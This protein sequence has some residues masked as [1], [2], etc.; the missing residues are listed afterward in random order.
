MRIPYCFNTPLLH[1][2]QSLFPF[3]PFSF[4]FPFFTFSPFFLF[5]FFLVK[6]CGLEALGISAAWT[7]P[8]QISRTPIFA[9]SLVLFFDF[10]LYS[11]LAFM[12]IEAHHKTNTPAISLPGTNSGNS[13]NSGNSG[14][15][16]N[17]ENGENN[18]GR[19]NGQS[20]N[21]NGDGSNGSNDR[22]NRDN[23]GNNV[24]PN[25]PHGAIAL[26]LW[27]L[28]ILGSALTYFLRVTSNGQGY[29]WGRDVHTY[30]TVQQHEHQQSNIEIYDAITPRWDMQKSKSF[31]ELGS[32]STRSGH[33]SPRKSP[34]KSIP[35]GS[36]S[37]PH[38][39]LPPSASSPSCVVPSSSLSAHSFDLH[40]NADNSDDNDD[41]AVGIEMT[42]KGTRA[43]EARSGDT[44]EGVDDNENRT[45]KNTRSN[46]GI[47]TRIPQDEE[48]KNGDYITENR[49]GILKNSLALDQKGHRVARRN[50]A[51]YRENEENVD[52]GDG[53]NE[54]YENRAE[55][56]HTGPTQTCMRI[57]DLSK[58][59]G[60]ASTGVVILHRVC[61]E[62]RQGTVTCLL[63]KHIVEV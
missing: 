30:A 50:A 17:S 41:I 48:K 34:R 12:A 23:S 2:L 49:N 27:T 35:S 46:T 44:R 8:A 43:D 16:E 47:N 20:D 63:G 62:L 4:F 25:T 42:V 3:F 29:C 38:F 59:F 51:N 24:Q 9:Y 14:N 60:T 45:A 7:Y 15:S 40:E 10:L 26:G 53:K 39:M 57:L 32:R 55:T 36:G 11:V 52:N 22:D 54:K 61:A 33:S 37:P 28:Q 18:N 21:D 13:K 58:E 19:N 1:N 6:V 31:D 56:G 5:P